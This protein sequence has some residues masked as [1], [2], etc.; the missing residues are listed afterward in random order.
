M[1]KNTNA[2]KL[3]SPFVNRKGETPLT[4]ILPMEQAVSCDVLE[5]HVPNHL[6]EFVTAC[7]KLNHWDPNKW[8]MPELV[9]Y[10]G[11]GLSLPQCLEVISVHLRIHGVSRVLT[12]QL[13]R[14]RVG[15]TFS[16]QCTGDTDMRHADFIGP[17]CFVAAE[18]SVRPGI[19]S[20]YIETVSL[21]KRAYASAVDSGYSVQEARYFLPHG[22]K[23]FIH[24]YASLATVVGLYHA[25]RDWQ[26]QTWEMIC[27]A[28]KMKAA[29]L[30][31]DAGLAFAGL[32]EP[33]PSW[34]H[35]TREVPFANTHLWAPSEKMGDDTFDWNP[36]SF[37]HGDKTHAEVSSGPA[38]EPIHILGDEVVGVVDWYDRAQSYGVV[39]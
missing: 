2:P 21:A 10:V 15:I 28:E 39:D 24:A 13:V 38:W 20:R 6:V 35:R 33:R 22:E 30:K 14:A 17:N 18:G 7:H 19:M 37:V 11:K 4:R 34:F 9:G 29:I 12:H 36:E 26:T 16:Q 23:S 3:I 8:T 1:P 27:L 25:R 5:L 31:H 32:F